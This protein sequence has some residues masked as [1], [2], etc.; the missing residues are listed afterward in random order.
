MVKKMKNQELWTR[1][2]RVKV[3]DFLFCL[4]AIILN[5]NVLMCNACM[6]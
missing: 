4:F 1:V 3:L 6:K 5:V 2:M